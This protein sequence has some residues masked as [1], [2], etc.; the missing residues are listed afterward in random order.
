MFSKF[1][2]TSPSTLALSNNHV[3]EYVHTILLLVVIISRSHDY[4]YQNWV[5]EFLILIVI[6]FDTQSDTQ[7]G[8]GVLFKF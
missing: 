8:F 7:T 5:F 1:S 6:N 3:S 2:S 4:I